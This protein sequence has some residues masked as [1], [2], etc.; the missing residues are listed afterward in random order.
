MISRRV[1][2]KPVRPCENRYVW[3][4]RRTRDPPS[5]PSRTKHVVVVVVVVVGI[6]AIASRFLPR[7]LTLRVTAL[8]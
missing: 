5:P 7:P 4:K 1:S 2:F 8:D 3:L 6:F